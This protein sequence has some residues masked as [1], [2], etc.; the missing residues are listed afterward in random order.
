MLKKTLC[1]M[2]LPLLLGAGFATSSDQPKTALLLID[3]Q[4][5]YFPGGSAALVE[6]EAASLNARKILD[7]FR[8]TGQLVIHITHNAKQ[9]ADIHKHV[10]PREDERV[11]S[12]DH[13]NAFR[14]TDLHAA[15]QSHAIKRLVI[16][17]M[18]TH[19]CVEAAVRAAADLGYEVTLIHDACATRQLTFSGHNVKAED[20]HNATLSTLARTYA[21]VIDTA[22]FLQNDQ[23]I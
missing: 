18:M 23:K 15:L 22:T 21:A 4:N 2:L 7:R 3:I 5:F 13:V 16:C 17:G 8:E 6:P 9:D 1:Y 11:I 20:V 19:M 12:K 14:E 10:R